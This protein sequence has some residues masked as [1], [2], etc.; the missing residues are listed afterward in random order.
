[1]GDYFDYIDDYM[2]GNLS[3]EKKAQFEK[4]LLKNE[5]LKVAVNNYND[6]KKLSEGFLEVDMLDTLSRVKSKEHIS[7]KKDNSV[8]TPKRRYL[9]GILILSLITIAVWWWAQ[10]QN[11]EDQKTQVLASYIKPV[12]INATK[13][14][15]TMGMTS[16]EKGKYFF[17][18]NRFDEAE[19]WLKLFV[20]EKNE[21]ISISRG[22]FWLGAAHLEQWELSDAKKAWKKSDEKEAKHNL[23]FID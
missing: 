5:S 17:S 2:M 19:L 9:I 23:K 13:S 21:K 11:I 16:F 12:D 10:Q 4:E 7:T 8:S 20:S 1:M 15:D 3:S 6:A 18:L 22:Y 14:I